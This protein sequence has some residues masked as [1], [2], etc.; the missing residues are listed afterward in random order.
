MSCGQTI[1]SD[2]IVGN[3]LTNCPGDGLRIGADAITLDLDGH[4]IDGDGPVSGEGDGDVGIANG[5]SPNGG[6]LPSFDAVT[7]RNGAIR[8]FEVGVSFYTPDGGLEGG[9][10]TGLS[11][12]GGGVRLFFVTDAR[13]EQ[14]VLTGGATIGMDMSSRNRV[15]GNRLSGGGISLGQS[16][17][18]VGDGVS[19]NLIA[20]NTVLDA[21]GD[22]IVFRDV[23]F[24]RFPEGNRILSN[25]VRRSSGDGIKIPDAA[26][27]LVDGN[28]VTNNGGDGIDSG[29]NIPGA[30]GAG[31]LTDNV[32][33]SNTALGINA[34]EGTDDGGGNRAQGNGDARQCVGWA[35]GLDGF[36][37]GGGNPGQS[38]S[39]MTAD[40]KR[41]SRCFLYFPAAIKQLRVYLDGGGATSGSQ[42]LRGIIYSE[43][44]GEPGRRLIRSFQ[45]RIQAGTAPGWVTLPLPFRVAA[46]PRL[47][48]ARH[49]LG[50]QQRRRPLRLEPRAQAR[51]ASTSTATST[52]PTTRSA[53]HRSTTS[54][55]PSTR[56]ATS[57]PS[58][59]S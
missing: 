21:P 15:T 45:T 57:E 31:T 56:S 3:D 9:L 7:V 36:L 6:D 35:V 54:R 22:G 53:Q 47:L 27:V 59:R 49:P 58:A 43:F 28:T 46:Q 29:D 17:R 25:T 42:V 44:G 2:T 26:A 34:D 30:F 23:V 33:D 52:V 11:M 38:F 10:I 40:A 24:E 48:L 5:Y 51:A 1:T 18:T 8:Q 13:I 32:A 39:A 37:F 41:A 55:S 50:R 12:E 4:T 16:F 14:N 20:G 19:D